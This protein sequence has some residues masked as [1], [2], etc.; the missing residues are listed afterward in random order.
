MNEIVKD[1][2]T[3]FMLA[4]EDNVKEALAQQPEPTKAEIKRMQVVAHAFQQA[5][6]K[7]R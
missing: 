2:H 3:D 1:L 4:Y 7:K 6:R 5:R